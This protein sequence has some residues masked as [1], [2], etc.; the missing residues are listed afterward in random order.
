MNDQAEQILND[1]VTVK[2]KLLAIVDDRETDSHEIS[3]KEELHY[4][5]VLVKV[6][7]AISKIKKIN[8]S[9]TANS[10][11]SYPSQPKK[12]LMARLREIKIEGNPDWSERHEEIL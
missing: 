7:Q 11:P 3:A 2:S 9:T 5:R 6:Q 12:S 10:E 4:N 8:I 1:L